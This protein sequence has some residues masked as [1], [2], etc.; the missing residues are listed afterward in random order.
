MSK[1]GTFIW[2]EAVTAD[3]KKSGEFYSA[4]L[5]W[6]R[7]ELDAGPFGTYTLFQQDGRDI[8]G[9]MNPTSDY[10]R[11]R[12]AWWSAYVDV[13]D[14]DNVAAR[15]EQLGGRVVE[16]ITDVPGFGRAC[17][18]ADSVGAIVCLVTPAAIEGQRPANG[19]FV[20]HHLV[21]TDQAKS[22]AFYSELL[23]WIRRE[24][25]AG[26]FGTYTIFQRD[27]EN[28]AGM[29]KPTIEYTRSRPPS[30][31]TYVSV[32]DVNACAARVAQLGGTVIEPPHD[33]P[34]VGR[35]CLIA[36]PMGAPITLMTPLPTK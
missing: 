16:P 3:Q 35:V 20:W 11:P 12:S 17:M 23:G 22:G 7:R 26:P 9:M 32:D 10:S 18:I 29:M 15:V 36:D 2:N 34:G 4:L 1:H 13:A 31:Y 33:V 14:V 30:W 24:V 25:D 6:S 8:A 19:P 28:I 21:T 27:G 5:G